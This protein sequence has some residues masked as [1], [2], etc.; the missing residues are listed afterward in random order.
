MLRKPLELLVAVPLISALASTQPSLASEQYALQNQHQKPAAYAQASKKDKCDSSKD[1]RQVGDVFKKGKHYFDKAEADYNESNYETAL[2][3]FNEVI[4]SCNNGE[5]R[6]DALLY[7]GMALWYGIRES[8]RNSKEAESRFKSVI[9]YG[10]KD[11]KMEQALFYRGRA[12]FENAEYDPRFDI[13]EAKRMFIMSME[14]FP[15]GSF[16][17]AA[18]ERLV[19][20]PELRRRIQFIRAKNSQKT[21]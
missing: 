10:L 19:E 9:D 8:R 17:A 5:F 16:Y 11:E 15:N 7:S 4:K 1:H 14:M 20:I 3:Y 18:N 2:K 21:K 12:H 6:R 13:D